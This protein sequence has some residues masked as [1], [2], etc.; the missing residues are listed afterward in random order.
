MVSVL[1][2]IKASAACA[3]PRPRHR[4]RSRPRSVCIPRLLSPAF[5]EDSR[6]PK[7]GG[8][9]SSAENA[10]A[11]WSAAALCRFGSGWFE[12]HLP[13]TK[14]RQT[15]WAVFLPSCESKG[16]DNSAFRLPRL[17]SPALAEDSRTPKPGGHSSSAENALA[18]WSAAALCRFASG[19]F[20]RHLPATKA[21]Q[22]LF[23]A[24]PPSCRTTGAVNSPFR[25]FRVFGG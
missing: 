2:S 11:F 12:R 5:A 16:A 9:S 1:L 6:T 23:A 7:P 4:P 17:L 8:H 19:W 20:E 25:V 22:P 14:A 13:A 10:L 3:N 18:F 15:L 24:F 21:R